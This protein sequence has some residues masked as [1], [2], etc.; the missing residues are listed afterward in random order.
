MIL[1]ILSQ[2]KPAWH[3]DGRGDW[4]RDREDKVTYGTFCQ[5][6]ARSVSL[7]YGFESIEASL[8]EY[9]EFPV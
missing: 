6:P 1:V 9:C 5:I 8:W 3:I 7:V 4:G 2:I